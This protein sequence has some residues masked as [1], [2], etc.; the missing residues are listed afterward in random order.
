MTQIQT[1]R[2]GHLFPELVNAR[3]IE[4]FD[5]LLA[6]D[7]VNHNPFVEQG[8]AGAQKFFTHLLEAVPDLHVTAE[9]VYVAD[10]GHHVIGRY[11]YAGTHRAPFFGYEATGQPISMRSID[12]WRVE[13]GRFVEHWDELNTL[14]VFQQIGA[15][16]MTGTGR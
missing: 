1:E 8:L 5:E 16:Q 11:S 12:V 15:V 4:R 6:R 7:Y 3:A 14:E 9:A 13:D 2:L 10:G